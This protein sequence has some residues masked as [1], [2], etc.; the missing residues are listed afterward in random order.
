MFNNADEHIN[1]YGDDIEV[2]YRGYEVCMQGFLS[3]ERGKGHSNTN[4]IDT[5][6]GITIVLR[7]LA[8][9]CYNLLEIFFYLAGMGKRSPVNKLLLI[10]QS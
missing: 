7:R 6:S 5:T 2:D 9:N 10:L 3:A 1:V 8:E 4:F